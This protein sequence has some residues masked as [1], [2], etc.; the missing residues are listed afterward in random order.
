MPK[1]NRIDIIEKMLSLISEKKNIK[2][3]HLMYKSNLSHVQ[4][5]GYLEELVKKNFITKTFNNK[6]NSYISITENGIKF[7]EKIREM[8]EFESAFGL[9]N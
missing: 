6:N 7:L 4:M 2:P 5:K 8:R 9:E 1:R 3:T